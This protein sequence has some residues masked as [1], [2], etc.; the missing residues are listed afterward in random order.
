MEGKDIIKSKKYCCLKLDVSVYN[1]GQNFVQ[2][3]LCFYLKQ[4]MLVHFNFNVKSTKI[5]LKFL[6]FLNK[7]TKLIQLYEILS[8]M[9]IS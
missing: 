2:R 4:A 8:H 7:E 6:S 5:K 9:D 3:Y 1:R